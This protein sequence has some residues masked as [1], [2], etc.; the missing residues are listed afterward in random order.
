MP[1]AYSY[2]RFSSDQQ[3]KGDSVRRQQSA[4]SRFIDEHPELDLT[5]DTTLNMHDLGVSAFKA[6][7]LTDGALG[8]FTA[9]AYQGAIEEGSYLLLENLDR[10]SRAEPWK[11]VNDLTSLV[12][13]G[14]IVVSLCDNQIFSE[15]TLSGEG[16]SYKLMQSVMTFMRAN[17]ESVQKSRRVAA[18][19]SAKFKKIADGI[20]LTKRVPFWINPD[21]KSKTLKDKVAIVKEMFDLSQKGY[22]ANSITKHLNAMG[23]PSATG[24]AK[25][26]SAGTVKK[27]L[28]SESVLGT[29]I[30]GNNQRHEGYFPKIISN[31]LFKQVQNIGQSSSTARV[32][33][34]KQHPLAGLMWCA[35]CG[36]KAHRSVKQGKVRKDGTKNHW[37]YMVCA[38]STESNVACKYTSIHY[39]ELVDA[40]AGAIEQHKYQNAK[41][42]TLLKIRELEEEY[43]HL[44]GLLDFGPGASPLSKQRYLEALD[45]AGKIDLEIKA[46]KGNRTPITQWIFE[47]AQ[48]KIIDERDR[49]GALFRQLVSRC[50]ID[51]PNRVIKVM[52]TDNGEEIFWVD[53]YKDIHEHA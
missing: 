20:Q 52:F 40:L 33:D 25:Y 31:K 24:R 15:L 9:L 13:A 38:Q 50:E 6:K 30:T 2:V 28:K 46:L 17:D 16:G 39:E 27:I 26:W 18:A 10:F 14:I 21:D 12:R 11:A 42:A 3:S 36:S 47:D 34:P 48:R 43:R 19:W 32:V 23:Y 29:L 8:K 37:T 49:S 51:F 44:E 5:L 1:I 4:A 7:N 22:G 53:H 45:R 41:D 35:H